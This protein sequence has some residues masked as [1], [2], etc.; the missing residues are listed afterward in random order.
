MHP[1]A[2]GEYHSHTQTEIS[3]TV[4]GQEIWVYCGSGGSVLTV[5]PDDTHH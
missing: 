1:A 5:I 2:N 4:P 3:Q